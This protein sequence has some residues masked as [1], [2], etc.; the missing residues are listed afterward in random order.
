MSATNIRN[1]NV[2]TVLRRALA[3]P[4]S[5]RGPCLELVLAEFVRRVTSGEIFWR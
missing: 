1:L 4:R 2:P 3:R 5:L